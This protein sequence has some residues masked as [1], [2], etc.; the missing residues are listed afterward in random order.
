MCVACAWWPSTWVGHT[1]PHPPPPPITHTTQRAQAGSTHPRASG[2]LRK[3]LGLS[4]T[5][6]AF[7]PAK[8][9]L[10]NY[11]GHMDDTPQAKRARPAEPAP[12][13]D[14][15]LHALLGWAA[16]HGAALSALA[17]V[18]AH[19]DEDDRGRCVPWAAAHA[20][21]HLAHRRTAHRGRNPPLR[22]CSAGRGAGREPLRHPSRAHLHPAARAADRRGQGDPRVRGARAAHRSASRGLCGHDCAAL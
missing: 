18:R 12:D 22:V 17:L 6:R 7:S 9:L 1:P 16:G 14:P 5:S 20:P 19:G 15:R 21:S 4:L 10:R 11:V 13:C 8:N 3:M 2:R